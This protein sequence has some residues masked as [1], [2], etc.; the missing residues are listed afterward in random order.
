MITIKYSTT[1]SRKRDKKR[2]RLLLIV[3]LYKF[4]ITRKEAYKLYQ[5]LKKKGVSKWKIKPLQ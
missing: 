2:K 4:H 5:D 3:G 1:E